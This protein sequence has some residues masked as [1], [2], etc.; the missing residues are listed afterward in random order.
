VFR[1][2]PRRPVSSVGD[3]VERVRLP[4]NLESRPMNGTRVPL[5]DDRKNTIEEEARVSSFLFATFRGGLLLLQEFFT[6]A[7][8]KK[9]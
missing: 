2:R 1:F 7:A 6:G 3:A 5:N 4:M 9:T 8:K